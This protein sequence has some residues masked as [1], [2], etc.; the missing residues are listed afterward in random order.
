MKK[1]LS[2]LII[3]ALCFGLVA[4]ASSQSPIVPSTASDTPSSESNSAPSGTTSAPTESVPT[5]TVPPETAPTEP[6]QTA[7]G[8]LL[9]K[10][11]DSNG[12]A[13][14][15]FGSIHVGREE[16]YPLPDYVMNAFNGADALA[17]EINV[18]EVESDQAAATEYLMGMV[19][20]DG[21]TIKDHIPAEL[22]DRCAAIFQENGLPSQTLDMFHAYLWMTLV[23]E[24]ALEKLS[25]DMMLG[26]DRHLMEKAAAA[27]KPILEV[28]NKDDHNFIF[29]KFS[30]ALSVMLLE[31]V[32]EMYED[33][34]Q[35]DVELIEMMDLWAA[36]DEQA[37]AEYL[38]AEDDELTAE[39]QKLY[40]EYNQYLLTDRNLIM[41]DWAEQALASGE[42]VF[43]TVGAAH[44]VGE[45]ALVEMLRQRGYTVELVTG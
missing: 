31:D 18:T 14:W 21:T 34:E 4:C 19:Y 35:A 33:P 12:N 1:L 28:E 11:T 7:D 17:V 40:E 6:E 44:V 38:A 22:Y 3:V 10:V 24:L 45:G 15:L 23:Q 41:A 2:L 43:I 30:D 27:G 29:R 37:F 39:E 16:F 42:E 20:T 25:G 36:G 13:A 26:V 8:P 32:V 9:Y 5:E